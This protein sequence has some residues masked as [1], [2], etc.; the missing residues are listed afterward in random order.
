MIAV[1]AI[2]YFS[3]LQLIQQRQSRLSNENQRR[4][5]HNQNETNPGR[6]DNPREPSSN[7]PN[8]LNQS[9][10]TQGDNMT[11]PKCASCKNT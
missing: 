3:A 2:G 1:S 6:T 9:S 10:N 7:K 11:K 5:R 4:T 8:D